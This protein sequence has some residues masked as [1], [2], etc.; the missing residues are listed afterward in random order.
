MRIV[1]EQCQ[2]KYIVPDDKIKKNVLRFTCQKCGHVITTRVEETSASERSTLGKWRETGINTPKRTKKKKAIWYYSYNGESFGPYTES[3]L[4][5]KL[6]SDKLSPIAQKCYVWNKNMPEWQP[7]MEVE[8]FSSSLLMPPPPAAPAPTPKTP[9]S[10]HLPPLF[11]ES[12]EHNPSVASVKTPSPDVKGLK[13]RLQNSGKSND[14]P[15]ITMHSEDLFDRINQKKSS[16]IPGLAPH[17]RQ[18]DIPTHQAFPAVDMFESSEENSREDETKVGPSPLLSFQ[19]LDAISPEIREETKTGNKPLSASLPSLSKLPAIGKKPDSA[20]PAVSAPAKLSA[21]AAF[22]P[23]SK[24]VPGISSL[25]GSTTSGSKPEPPKT[26]ELPKLEGLKSLKPQNDTAKSDIPTISPKDGVLN[27]ADVLLKTKS[28]SE[29][30][31][32]P[33]DAEPQISSAEIELNGISLE[34]SEVDADKDSKPQADAEI[35]DILPDVDLENDVFADNKKDEGVKTEKSPSRLGLPSIFQENRGEINDEPTAVGANILLDSILNPDSADA[36]A[37]ASDHTS[38]DSLKVVSPAEMLG[39]S[40][41]TAENNEA[42]DTPKPDN[43][44]D[45]LKP[46]TANEM[47]PNTAA[48]DASTDISD[49]DALIIDEPVIESGAIPCVSDNAADKPS[50]NHDDLFANADKLS[51]DSNSDGQHISEKSMMLQLEHFEKQRAK[52]KRRIIIL[53]A[54]VIIVILAIVLG[55]SLSSSNDTDEQNTTY[56]KSEVGTFAEV[57]GRTVT[58]DELDESLIP[59][60]EFEIIAVEDNAPVRTNPAAN[61]NSGSRSARPKS[62]GSAASQDTAE[63]QEPQAPAAKS[64]GRANVVLKP[65]DSFAST[66]GVSGTKYQINPGGAPTANTFS[67]G[68]RSVGQTIQECYKREAKFGNMQQV[69]KIYIRLKVNPTGAVDS[70]EVEDKSIPDSFTKCLDSKKNQN[71]WKFSPFEG[72]AVELRQ[73]FVLDK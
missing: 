2:T 56:S 50:D 3:E 14:K 18:D 39:L 54:V 52:N 38:Q 34:M 6:L 31:E 36:E 69:Q 15:T 30:P 22:S 20:K 25:F 73:A 71:R 65:Q 60:D 58:S 24:Q 57:T 35:P 26:S 1:C 41:N 29:I 7:V 45:T 19:S 70:F 27:A 42:K 4:K 5:D 13:Q 55:V 49:A 40:K 9:Q 53:I 63:P 66:E 64:D 8:P 16:R 21:P 59:K 37:D 11:S 72:K 44:K 46:D 23:A 12:C 28:K 62:N 51:S 67:I 17:R 33:A 48:T 61:S 10:D 47:Q 68:L 32:P 43:D